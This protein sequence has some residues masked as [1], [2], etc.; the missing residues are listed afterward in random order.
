MRCARVSGIGLA[1]AVAVVCAG[2]TDAGPSFANS[3][4]EVVR[5]HATF[6]SGPPGHAGSGLNLNPG[7]VFRDPVEQQLLEITVEAH[8]QQFH[9]SAD[10]V[11]KARRDEAAG[12]QMWLF[13]GTSIC[14]LTV[15]RYQ[16]T[17]RNRCEIS[18]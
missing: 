13:D 6:D 7:E 14:M 8:G 15:Q 5:V 16:S 11:L 18:K 10:E 4:E 3:A 12:K 9:L 17:Q 1:C 2:C